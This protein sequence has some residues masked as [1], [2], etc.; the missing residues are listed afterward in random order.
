MIETNRRELEWTMILS[1]NELRAAARKELIEQWACLKIGFWWGR[2]EHRARKWAKEHLVPAEKP[3]P[4]SLRT[5]FHEASHDY[6]P[7]R[8]FYP[9]LADM[10]FK[11]A[12]GPEEFQVY[13]RFSDAIPTK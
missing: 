9:A 3:Y 8:F 13:A 5:R 2:A 4:G 6:F 12:G 1:D 7:A 11:V 10:G